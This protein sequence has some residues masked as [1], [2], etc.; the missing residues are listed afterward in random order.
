LFSVIEQCHN[1]NPN[2]NLR[3]CLEELQKFISKEFYEDN[4]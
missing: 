4:D 1:R 3:R 2:D